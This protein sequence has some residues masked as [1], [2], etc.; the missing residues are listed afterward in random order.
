LTV[1]HGG[2]GGGRGEAGR[3]QED[4]DT[5]TSADNH[6]QEQLDSIPLP[7]FKDQAQSRAGPPMSSV[8]PVA[9][10]IPMSVIDDHQQPATSSAE[11]GPEATLLRAQVMDPDGNLVQQST[12]IVAAPS[13][14][15]SAATFSENTGGRG[16]NPAPPPA[17]SSK[18][19]NNNLRKKQAIL[20]TSALVLLGV[21][22]AVAVTLSG[23]ASDDQGGP[24]AEAASSP[25]TSTPTRS[26]RPSTMF[27][28]TTQ[29]PS[30]VALVPTVAPLVSYQ[31]Q[32]KLTA[33]NSAIAG[34]QFGFS[35]AIHNA[36]AVVGAPNLATSGST[37]TVG[38]VYVFLRNADATWSE[39]AQQLSATTAGDLFGTRVAVDG[40]TIVVGARQDSDSRGSAHVFVRSGTAAWTEQ[41][42][43]I[44]SDGAATDFFGTSVAIE[45]DTIVVGADGADLDVDTVR[46]S[47]SVYVY[48]RS[49][50]S[51]TE[52]AKLTAS[53]GAS[54]DWFGF[55]VAISGD[56]LV[57][58]ALGDDTDNGGDVG[59]AYVFIRSDADTNDWTE[60]AK[61]TA[62]DGSPDEKFGSS[63]AISGETVV[64]TAPAD[65]V[66]GV[67]SGSAY[68]FIRSGTSWTEQ[69]KL[70]ASDGA[71]FESFGSS[72]VIEGD[73]VVIGANTGDTDNGIDSGSAYMYLRS[74]SAWTEQAKYVASD[75]RA[76]DWF[77]NSVAISE[78]TIIVGAHSDD[79]DGRNSGSAY[80]FD[81]P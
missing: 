55:S 49:G 63:V 56:T 14:A 81:V 43:L 58:G 33:G 70:I 41:A 3:D 17:R 23:T 65:A 16:D 72:V 53:D 24:L 51:W 4:E 27:P 52:Q 68:V 78:G 42:K 35:V 40:N 44:A 5:A 75:G 30:A 6:Q 26:F 36:T 32:T 57:V 21:V 37:T 38:S 73:V 19:T 80:I 62:I 74:G 76:A 60:Q 25:A 1:P 50:S 2:G 10:G 20:W 46:D 77:G 71:E 47:C 22:I 7:S 59:S 11:N 79:D 39:P 67:K 12:I 8:L 64:V 28:S 9:Q 31:E 61:L 48:T 18:T 54:S 66:V 34:E 29:P 69:A 13:N 15:S 45:G